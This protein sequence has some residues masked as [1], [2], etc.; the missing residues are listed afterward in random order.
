MSKNILVITGS[1]REGGNSE[2]MADAF[3]AGAKAKGHET[4]KFRAAAKKINGCT[5]CNTCWSK[6]RACS[7]DDGFT[8]L[9]PLLEKADVLVFS[10]P[11][12]WFGMTAQIKAAIDKFYA[13]LMDNCQRPLHIKES[14][15]LIC[16]EGKEIES[17]NGAVETYKYT[18]DYWRWKDAGVLVVPKV[19]A[20]GAIAKTD[21]LA[22]AEELGRSI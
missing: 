7:F 2:L 3:I 9:E 14:A 20:K 11:L 16:G 8:E 4:V 5:A 18:A 17:F 13:Y 21:A 15:L 6:G 10:S 12:Y 22:R 19:Y 1:P